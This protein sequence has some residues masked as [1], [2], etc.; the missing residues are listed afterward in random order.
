MGYSIED[1]ENQSKLLFWNRISFTLE[2]KTVALMFLKL[3][4]SDV[5]NNFLECCLKSLLFDIKI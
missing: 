2:L 1:I 4:Q 3:L 5:A